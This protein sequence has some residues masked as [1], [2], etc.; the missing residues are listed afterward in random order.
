MTLGTL[1]SI[2]GSVL[3]QPGELLAED[4][5]FS[6]RMGDEEAAGYVRGAAI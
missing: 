6:L 3:R 2:K 1:E 4:V 5:F